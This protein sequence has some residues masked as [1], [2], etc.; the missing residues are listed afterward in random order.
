MDS[1]PAGN[2][3]TTVV[4]VQ[5]AADGKWYVYVEGTNTTQAIPLVPVTLVVRL[6]RASETG[7]LR[8]SIR[9]H[10]S[11]HWAPIQSNGQLEELVRAWLLSG[12][13]GN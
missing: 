7:L 11:D 10:G 5:M 12:A 9:L 1:E 2:Y 13:P 4:R 6:W 3:I 8:G